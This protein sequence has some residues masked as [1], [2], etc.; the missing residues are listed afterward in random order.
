MKI[1]Y[2]I[3]PAVG[4]ELDIDDLGDLSIKATN[5]HG[6]EYYLVIQTV[7]G[8]TTLFE[9]G[10]AHPDLDTLPKSVRCSFDRIDF[11]EGKIIKR[12]ERFLNE[13]NRFIEDAAVISKEEA[14]MGCRD[15]IDYVRKGLW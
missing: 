10:P 11:S 15:V 12:I 5:A 6:D 13:G 1:E 4:K 7:M 9:Y 2:A 3:I 14:L 8:S